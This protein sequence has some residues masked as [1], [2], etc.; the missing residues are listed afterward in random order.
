MCRWVEFQS[1]TVLGIN[2]CLRQ[3]LFV[4]IWINWHVLMSGG[5][6][7]SFALVWQGDPIGLDVKWRPCSLSFSPPMIPT[8][9]PFSFLWCCSHVYSCLLRNEHPCSVL[10]LIF[11]YH[12]I[13]FCVSKYIIG[14]VNYHRNDWRLKMGRNLTTID[15]MSTNSSILVY[16]HWIGNITLSNPL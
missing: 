9:A 3:F 2:E 1:M 11:V 10:T 6:G 7:A 16:A 5:P 12:C 14:S 15:L 8:P 13:S 4:A